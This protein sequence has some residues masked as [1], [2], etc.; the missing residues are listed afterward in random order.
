MKH[1]STLIDRAISFV[2]VIVVLGV[3]G[4]ID[5]ED[6]QKSAEVLAEA[7]KAARTEMLNHKREM[8]ALDTRARFMTSHDLIA[9]AK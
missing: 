1:N 4:A 7:K 6:K 8:A 2:A 9:R 3:M 5:S